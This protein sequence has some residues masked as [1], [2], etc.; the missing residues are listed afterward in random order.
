MGGCRMWERRAADSDFCQVRIGVGTLPLATPADCADHGLSWPA[1]SG[2][3]Q[4][5]ARLSSDALDGPGRTNRDR[6]AGPDGGEH[7]R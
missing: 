2:S 5:A 4:C 6:A 1:G 3:G 7:R